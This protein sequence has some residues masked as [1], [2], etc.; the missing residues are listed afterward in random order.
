MHPLKLFTLLS[1]SILILNQL[2][3][4]VTG[5]SEYRLWISIAL[6]LPLLIPLKG[7]WSDQRYTYKWTGF[8]PMLY[9][10]IGVSEAFVTAD[11]S[12]YGI[13]NILASGVLFLASMYYSRY[14]RSQS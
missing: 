5:T 6:T 8:L 12:Y 13:I 9:F 2:S 10:A 3:L 7:L 14:L 4:L 1:I 11:A